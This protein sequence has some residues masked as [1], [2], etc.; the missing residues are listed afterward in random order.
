MI[1][2]DVPVAR[3]GEM[4][5]GP[6][7]TPIQ[8]GRDGR[9]KIY[10]REA[11][12]FSPKSMASLNGKPV[13]DDHPPVDVS[14]QNWQFY[15]KGVV[16]N[17]RRG[18]G[19]FSNFLMADMIIFDAD[20]IEAIDKGKLEVSCGYNPDYLEMLSQDG[21]VIPG[22]GEQSNIVYNHLAM[23]TA[24]RCGYKCAIRDHK[25]VDHEAVPDKDE[26]FWS[27]GRLA[28][29]ARLAERCQA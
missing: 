29:L 19:E 15:T 26:S 6:G 9:V 23:V 22:E 1:C 11:E 3:T 27:E 21:N 2:Y 18:D 28:R 20:L 4:I 8:L 16:V 14:P 10:R 13:T 7:E 24:G 17:P 25:T 5:Y 12:V